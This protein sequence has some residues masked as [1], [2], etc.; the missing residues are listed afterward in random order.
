M[1]K[2]KF[3]V[4]FVISALQWSN[5]FILKSFY[6]V[7]LTWSKTYCWW[8]IGN[9]QGRWNLWVGGARGHIFPT[10]DFGRNTSKSCSM[11]LPFPLDYQ[12]FHR[13]LKLFL[14]TLNKCRM[15]IV[16]NSLGFSAVCRPDETRWARWA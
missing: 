11:K 2:K 5:S 10:S 3:N 13:P 8:T 9:V 7:P 1:F 12:T 15:F 14:W 16:A 6:Q 4:I